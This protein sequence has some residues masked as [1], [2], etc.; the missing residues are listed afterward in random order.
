MHNPRITPTSLYGPDMVILDVG[1]AVVKGR[2]SVRVGVV[3]PRVQA[4]RIV[5]EGRAEQ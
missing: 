4:E 3:M 1:R 2:P 5:N